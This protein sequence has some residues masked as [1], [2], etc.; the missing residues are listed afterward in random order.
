MADLMQGTI[1]IV[2][3]RYPKRIW[4]RMNSLI[5]GHFEEFENVYQFEDAE[6]INGEFSDLEE[7]LIEQGIPFDRKSVGFC[8]IQPEHRIFRPGIIDRV[9]IQ[10]NAGET[11]ITTD[12]LRLVLQQQIPAEEMVILIQAMV[13]KADPTYPDL[14][15]YRFLWVSNESNEP[16][17]PEE[18]KEE[19]GNIRVLAVIGDVT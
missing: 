18:S 10:N 19:D 15:N 2:K 3:G 1:E 4:E 7:F 6:A 14:M 5:G 11:Y 9:L 8:E 17:F 13:D 12:F 16:F